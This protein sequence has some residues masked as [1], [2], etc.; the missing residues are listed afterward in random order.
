MLFAKKI[1][2]TGKI[3][4]NKFCTIFEKIVDYLDFLNVFLT[5][6]LNSDPDPHQN[7]KWDPDPFK[8]VVPDPPL[9]NRPKGHFPGISFTGLFEDKENVCATTEPNE[10]EKSLCSSLLQYIK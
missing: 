6:K 2:V 4:H 9:C 5:N 8:I 1:I 10:I 3:T 7:K